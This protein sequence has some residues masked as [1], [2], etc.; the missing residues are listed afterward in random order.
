MLTPA[1][2]SRHHVSNLP[3]TPFDSIIHLQRTI[4]NQA[5]QSLM[6]SDAELDSG[7]FKA[8]PQLKVSQPGDTYEREADSLAEQVMQMPESQLQLACACGGGCSKCRM[9]KMPE[10][11]ELLQTKHV[12]SADLGQ[13][14]VPPL[15]KEVLSVPGQSL[16]SET[17]D[18]MG[19]R[20]GHDFGKVRVHADHL[21]A[22][23]AETVGAKA[24]TVGS[25]VV[26]G[27]G[28]Y[29]PTTHDGQRLLAHELVHVLQ[30]SANATSHSVSGDAHIRVPNG[31]MEAEGADRAFARHV[32]TE[33]V[34]ARQSGPIKPQTVPTK[35]VFNPGVMHNH[36]PSGRW[37]DVQ[38][39]PN[40]P[41][42][43]GES[44][45]GP[46]CARFG[47]RIVMQAAGFATM[48]GMQIASDHLS[49]F[50]DQGN[51]AD[52]VEDNNLF[53]MLR[54]DVGVQNKIKTKIPTGR[55]SGTLK[56]H[57]K[58]TQGDYG[59]DEFQL[60]FGAIDRLDFE[61]DFATDTLHAWFQDRYE[62]HP[63]YPFYT[64]FPDDVVRET[65]CVHAAGVELKSGTARDYWMK[66]EATVHGSQIG[67]RM[68]PSRPPPVMG[69]W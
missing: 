11:R 43:Y 66:G 62:W 28:R 4:G 1:I 25:D 29:S 13:T 58:I 53:E 54:T 49:W 46:I 3:A 40:S 57:V 33:P 52:F 48:R 36:K 67:V 22:L 64:K 63:V 17:R 61:V 12:R 7:K 51:G 23:S 30:Q 26:M 27:R 44:V 24:Y 10:G 31:A 45:I 47:P 32:T 21:A 65:N 18:F 35:T 2:P 60:A 55:S 38:A 8:Q 5:I 14:A 20:F 39:A 68:G 34:L 37:A 42:A 19:S 6:R 69:P 41:G 9:N 16:D 50:L 59:D 15:V 56:S